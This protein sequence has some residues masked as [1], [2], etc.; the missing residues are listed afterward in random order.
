MDIGVMVAEQILT[1]SDS[2]MHL[3]L[4]GGGPG[5]I[6]PQ[7]PILFGQVVSFEQ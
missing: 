2:V 5:S 4:G 3:K 7:N 1:V 6:M